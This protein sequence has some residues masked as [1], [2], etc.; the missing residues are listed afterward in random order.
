MEGIGRIEPDGRTLD[1]M[2][3]DVDGCW[4]KQQ[5]TLDGMKRNDDYVEDDATEQFVFV[6]FTMMACRR[7]EKYFL[8]LLCVFFFFLII[9]FFF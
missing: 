4:S 2:A 1:G 8:L 7:E 5:R 3:R 9:F 6:S